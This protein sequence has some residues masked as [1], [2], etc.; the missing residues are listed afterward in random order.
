[1]AK[2]LKQNGINIGQNRFFE[3]LR[4][5]RYLIGRGEQYNLP[6]QKGMDLG[7]F[8]VKTTTITN[9]DGSVRVTRTT[10]I[11]PKGQIYFINKLLKRN[12]RRIR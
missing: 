1:M 3:W 7:L 2:I 11:K 6:S 4:E 9:S 8:E 5:N 12:E 10:K